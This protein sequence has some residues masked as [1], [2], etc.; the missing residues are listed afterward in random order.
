MK[1]ARTHPS[2][3]FLNTHG[4]LRLRGR[5]VSLRAMVE[6]EDMGGEALGADLPGSDALEDRRDVAVDVIPADSLTYTATWTAVAL[7]LVIFDSRRWQAPA[8]SSAAST[9]RIAAPLEASIVKISATGHRWRRL[10]SRSC[11]PPYHNDAEVRMA[12]IR[13]AASAMLVPR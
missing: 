10:G 11:Q 1:T 12:V 7:A 13:S 9:D 6:G 5:G 4:R 8:D 3:L 2:S